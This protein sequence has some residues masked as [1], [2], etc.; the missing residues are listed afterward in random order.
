MVS[1]VLADVT[2]LLLVAQW[3]MWLWNRRRPASAPG[4][5]RRVATAR[6][7]LGWAVPGLAYYPAMTAMALHG[8]FTDRSMVTWVILTACLALVLGL[9]LRRDVDGVRGAWRDSGYGGWRSR[10]RARVRRAFESKTA[11]IQPAGA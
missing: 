8:L 6:T 7:Q 3:N 1:L 10:L 2:L 9:G 11:A 4:S 5:L